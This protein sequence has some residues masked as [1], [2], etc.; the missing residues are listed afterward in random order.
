MYAFIEDDSDSDLDNVSN[1]DDSEESIDCDCDLKMGSEY[2]SDDLETKNTSQAITFY[3][4]ET[5][6]LSNLNSVII[7]RNQMIIENNSQS[8]KF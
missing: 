7:P 6:K 8:L 3:S 1:N 2:S 5:R 4:K